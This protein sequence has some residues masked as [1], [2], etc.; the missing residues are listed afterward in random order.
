MK[1]K[2]IIANVPTLEPSEAD[3]F[4]RNILGL[5]LAMDHG[6]I[7]TYS[8]SAKMAVQ[9]SFA[10]Q[11][12]SDTPVPDLSIEVDDL[13]EA[14]R[15]VQKPIFPWSMA[16]PLSRGVFAGSM[17]GIHSASSSTFFS[18]SSR[19]RPNSSFNMTRSC[20]SGCPACRG[21]GLAASTIVPAPPIISTRARRHGAA[22]RSR[23]AAQ[24]PPA[25]SACLGNLASSAANPATR[26][27]A[28]RC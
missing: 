27:R 21:V 7:R 26:S 2:R 17:S 12:G 25:N 10:S 1:V 18:M 24:T 6:W 16:P 22:A 4:Y 14:L 15:R 5:E 28:P 9:V 23:D 20:R 11:G 8:G 3:D 13:D 19:A